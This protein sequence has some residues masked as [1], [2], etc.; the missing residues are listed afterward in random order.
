M[1]LTMGLARRHCRA[2]PSDDEVLQVYAQAACSAAEAFLGRR[3]FEDQQS[4]DAAIAGIPTALAAADAAYKSA[5]TAAELLEGPQR[6]YALAAAAR[7]LDFA[8]TS[9]DRIGLGIV[10]NDHIRAGILLILGHL[11]RN[12]EDVMTEQGAAAV[13]LPMGA[14]AL[15]WPYRVGLGV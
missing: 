3:L 14:H 4:L 12:R 2:D 9:A 5:I 1:L 13:Q 7:A 8:V 10:V 11:Y 6:I 15:L